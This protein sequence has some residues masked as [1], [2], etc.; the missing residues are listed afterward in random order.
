M[1]GLL[2]G[3]CAIRGAGSLLSLVLIFHLGVRSAFSGGGFTLSGLLLLL[4]LL[5]FLGRGSVEDAVDLALEGHL[6]LLDVEERGGEVLVLGLG[7]G[8]RVQRQVVL[9]HHGRL[10]HDLLPLLV[11]KVGHSAEF[12]LNRC[13]RLLE[14]VD[15]VGEL[16]LESPAGLNGVSD[17][18]EGFKTGALLFKWRVFAIAIDPGFGLGQVLEEGSLE[19]WVDELLVVAVLVNTVLHLVGERLEHVLGLLKVEEFAVFKPKLGLEVFELGLGL[20]RDGVG[21]GRERHV[22]G[23]L[24][25]P[26]LSLVLLFLRHGWGGL[27]GRSLL[28]LSGLLTISGGGLWLLLRG[29]GLH[30]TCGLDGDLLLL[31]PELG[32]LDLVQ[33]RD[34]ADVISD[35]E[36]ELGGGAWDVRPRALAST[37]LVL[38][39]CVGQAVEELGALVVVDGE[40]HVALLVVEFER[41]DDRELLPRLDSSSAS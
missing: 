26:D 33:L 12:Q 23:A 3:S 14:Q 24:L 9:L 17:G 18:L 41:L 4:L 31:G 7:L 6:L 20:G 25:L 10:V 13:L 8:L 1:R 38:G 16:V 27:L 22:D 5:L 2:R 29:G 21:D 40:A 11:G 35:V 36:V 30:A 39:D 28:T 34:R 15:V 19:G 37:D 32:Q